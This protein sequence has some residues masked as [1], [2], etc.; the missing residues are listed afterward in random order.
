MDKFSIFSK[1]I[2]C[3]YYS[4]KI[5]KSFVLT[6][7]IFVFFS[8]TWKPLVLQQIVNQDTL[9]NSLHLIVNSNFYNFYYS[10]FDVD[11][12]ISNHL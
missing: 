10:V 6:K 9:K 1:N 11:F 4:T 2:F 7:I 3:F 8:E 5:I 12:I